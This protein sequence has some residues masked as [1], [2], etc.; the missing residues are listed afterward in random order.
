MEPRFAGR[1]PARSYTPAEFHTGVYPK[2][3]LRP[4]LTF[5]EM[6][7]YLDEHLHLQ[8]LPSNTP[9]PDLSVPNFVA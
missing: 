9:K 2:G 4:R 3:Q 7:I 8:Y 5:L 6:S 1:N